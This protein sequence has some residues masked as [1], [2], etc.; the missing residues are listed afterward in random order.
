[1]TFAWRFA[2]SWG[3]FIGWSIACLFVLPRFPAWAQVLLYF[4]STN[5]LAYRWG[6]LNERGRRIAKHH[7]DMTEVLAI[8]ERALA[9]CKQAAGKDQCEQNGTG[10]KG[11][12]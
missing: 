9:L 6:V 2:R 10:N 5:A 4:A 3:P 11:E 7:R 8:A 1:M 12:G